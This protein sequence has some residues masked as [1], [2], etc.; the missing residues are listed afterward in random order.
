MTLVWLYKVKLRQNHIFQISAF[1]SVSWI[2]GKLHGI[3]MQA[4]QALKILGNVKES[5][6]KSWYQHCDFVADRNDER[7][8]ET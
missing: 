7:K 4:L 3:S 6:E 5:F 8:A 1:F 2:E